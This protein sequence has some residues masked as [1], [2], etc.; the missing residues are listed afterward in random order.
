MVRPPLR[1]EM[2]KDSPLYFRLPVGLVPPSR[3]YDGAKNFSDYLYEVRGTIKGKN[4]LN[5]F[6]AKFL[7]SKFWGN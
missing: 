4:V 3:D 7:L 1:K 6:F 2:S 5:R